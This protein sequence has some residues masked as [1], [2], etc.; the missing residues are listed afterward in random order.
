MPKKERNTK[1]HNIFLLSK[2]KV[3]EEYFNNEETIVEEAITKIIYE[4]GLHYEEQ[5][6]KDN[7]YEENFHVMLFFHKQEVAGNKLA[8]F[9]K[10][11]VKKDQD[12]VNFRTKSASSILFIWDK[13]HIFA[14]TTGQGFRAIDEFCVPK[15]GMLV[16]V[17][18]DIAF[19]VVEYALGL[20]NKV[21]A[22][23]QGFASAIYNVIKTVASTALKVLLAPFIGPFAWIVSLIFEVG[24]DIID[25]FVDLKKE[26]AKF[27]KWVLENSWPFVSAFA[28]ALGGKL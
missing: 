21:Q 9:C 17:G 24:I 22:L 14:I 28:T 13:K 19:T 20:I 11:F 2:E 12:I 6:L 3:Q 5:V 15:F 26:I 18:I 4:A 7:L 25:F 8:S 1:T 27:V 10:P 23:S 16:D